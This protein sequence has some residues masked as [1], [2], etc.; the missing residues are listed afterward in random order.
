[1]HKINDF[2]I[3]FP[4]SISK[5]DLKSFFKKKGLGKILDY[6]DDDF[7]QREKDPRVSLKAQ[8]P[9]LNDLYR[10]YQFITLNK[11]TM[12]MEFGCGFSTLIFAT[13]VKENENL[14]RKKNKSKKPFERCNHPFQLFTVDN[15]KRFMSLS[16]KR[17]EKS[18]KK[19]LK[20]NF[21]FSD[22]QMTKINNNIAVEYK[23][24]PRVNPDFIYID[25]PSQWGV[26][27]QINNIN[28]AHSDMM[29]MSC[30]LI[31]I[32]NF[33]TPGT[34]ILLD[35]RTANARFL[36]NN[37]KRNWKYFEDVKN[38]QNIFLLSEK[39][40]GKHNIKQ[41]KYYKFLK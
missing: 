29:P 23:K 4:K 38:D 6:V 19:K 18:F 28:T 37:F 24:L 8:P 31:K 20:I 13:A 39:P 2:K 22:A 3:K 1:M 12:P 15:N 32:E 26:K 21:H 41:L 9:D 11:R 25:G 16:K 36:L 35:G 30:D 40:L 17:I 14:F 7:E 10:L 34:I 5:K 27:G 33:L